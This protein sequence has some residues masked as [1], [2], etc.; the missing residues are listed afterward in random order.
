MLN[1]ESL[2]FF[3]EQQPFLA[4][5]LLACIILAIVS[6]A[7]GLRRLDAIA[8][9][10]SKGLFHI[11]VAACLATLIYAFLPMLVPSENLS[12]YSFALGLARIPLYLMAL[13]YGPTAG[14]IAGALFLSFT[15]L[16]STLDL[17]LLLEL[18]VLGW[19]AIH[20][21][22]RKYWWAGPVGSLF[23]YCLTWAAAGSAYLQ[24]TAGTAAQLSSHWALHSS[25]LLGLV[26]TCVTLALFTPAVYDALFSFS[27]I[28]LDNKISS[29]PIKAPE[30]VVEPSFTASQALQKSA[31][32]ENQR[33][34]R[35]LDDLELPSLQR[36][37][38]PSRAP[39]VT[40]SSAGLQQNR[41]HYVDS[42]KN[43]S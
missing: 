40:S 20:P 28:A 7:S 14:I 37:E 9:F 10:S 21:S 3:Y 13:A 27:R 5:A 18:S 19:F 6:L 22:P 1:L 11:T 15:G 2:L 29:S 41:S 23:A 42:P 43:Q 39:H 32:L 33:Q 16:S 4:Y 36:Q 31:Q 17:I 30:L 24:W 12:A 8:T 35:Q 26:L 38:K 34:L 25:Q